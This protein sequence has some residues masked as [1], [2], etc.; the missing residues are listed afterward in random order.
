M[1]N[2][3]YLM[4][5][6][7]YLMTNIGYLMTIKRKKYREPVSEKKQKSFQTTSAT[8]PYFHETA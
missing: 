3:G 6:I 4:T 5:K 8:L 1:R 2:I 7:G